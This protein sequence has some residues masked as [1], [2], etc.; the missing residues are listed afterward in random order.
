MI[1]HFDWTTRALRP[2]NSF[3][4]KRWN[5]RLMVDLRNVLF[6]VFRYAVCRWPCTAAEQEFGEDHTWN[7]KFALNCSK[8]VNI[9]A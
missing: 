1:F 6:R 3:H 5:L 7:G 2:P 8:R 9:C 4:Q